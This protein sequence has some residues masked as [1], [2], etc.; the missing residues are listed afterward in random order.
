[1]AVAEGEGDDE[2]WMKGDSLQISE[3]RPT[4]LTE[5]REGIVSFRVKRCILMLPG[6]LIRRRWR[7]QPWSVIFRSRCPAP[8]EGA[9]E[10]RLRFALRRLYHLSLSLCPVNPVVAGWRT[11]SGPHPLSLSPPFFGRWQQ[12]QE[13]VLLLEVP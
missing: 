11:H 1:M 7:R 9:E 10:E 4:Q 2:G 5:K 12:Q 8:I 3:R 6:G 13:E